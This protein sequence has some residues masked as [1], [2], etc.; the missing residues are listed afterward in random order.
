MDFLM[1]YGIFKQHLSPLL[2]QRLRHWD[3][4]L[5]ESCRTSQP[6]SM[7]PER[8][9]CYKIGVQSRV[10]GE[11]QE[12]SSGELNQVFGLSKRCCRSK[13]NN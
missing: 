6:F 9:V 8:C 7:R 4:A 3:P 11:W 1:F 10:C 12:R 5:A 13:V 2:S